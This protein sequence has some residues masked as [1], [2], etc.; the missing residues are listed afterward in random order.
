MRRS[1]LA[2]FGDGVF[3]PGETVVGDPAAVAAHLEAR[4]AARSDAQLE[5][6][7]AEQRARHLRVLFEARERE[8][9]RPRPW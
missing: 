2:A 4:R 1:L 7:L 9:M 3:Q 6:E 8:R 5:V